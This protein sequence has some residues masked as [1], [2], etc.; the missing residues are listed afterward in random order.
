MPDTQPKV[1]ISYSWSNQQHKDRVREWAEHLITDG[2][3]VVMDVFD[4]KEGDDKYAYMERMVNDDSVTHVLL[5]CDGHYAEKADKQKGS[6]GVG[7]ESQII[8]SE[9]YSQIQQSKFI[10][11]F[12]EFKADGN[13]CVPVFLKTRFGIDFSTFEKANEN[14]EQLVRLLYGKPLY[15]KPELGKPPAYITNNAP[16]PISPITVKFETLKVALLADRKGISI[17]RDDFLSACYETADQLRVRQQPDEN[18]FPDQVVE[19]CTKL[20]LVRNALVDWVRLEGSIVPAHD[21]SDLL[22]AVLEKLSELKTRPG[23]VSSFN[24]SWFTAHGIF[25]YESFLYMVAELLRIKAYAA[26]HD[27]FSTHYLNP[28]PERSIHDRF[29]T[30]RCFWT[31]TADFLQAPLKPR[32]NERFTNVVGEILHR[33]ADRSD[34]PFSKL[35]EAELLVMLMVVLPPFP[36]YGHWHPHT[37]IYGSYSDNNEFFLRATQHRFFTDFAVI[38]GIKTADELRAL[39]TQGIDNYSARWQNSGI[40][41]LWDKLNMEKLDSLK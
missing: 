8:S 30:F 7:T 1:F 36:D 9:L 38:T 5:F 29:S 27:V 11:I 13:P 2:V 15:I 26:L 22:H 23:E 39:V 17:Y 37:F 20:K 31:P 25:A 10:P 4:L 40:R 6:S 19:T 3:Q 32:P 35:I 21:Y 41:G 12:C 33:Q 18:T 14:W 16:T 24:D 28:K 34:I